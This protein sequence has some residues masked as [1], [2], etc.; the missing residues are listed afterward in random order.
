[1]KPTVPNQPYQ[2]VPDRTKNQPYH[3]TNPFRGKGGLVR[4]GIPRRFCFGT[5]RETVIFAFSKLA[6]F[7]DIQNQLQAVDQRIPAYIY[8]RERV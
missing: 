2:T 7:F 3:R 6:S 1:V 5:V 4:Y 8:T